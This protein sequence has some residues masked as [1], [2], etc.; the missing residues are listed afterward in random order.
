MKR[1]LT[2]LRKSINMFSVLFAVAL[3]LS[4]VA[5][6][7]PPSRAWV[8]PFFGLAYIPLLLINI[9]FAAF[10]II[11]R[12][13]HAALPL[14]A[15]LLSWNSFFN[16]FAFHLSSNTEKHIGDFRVMSYNVRNFDLYNW[17]ANENTR[18]NMFKQIKKI[19]PD[20]V[21]FQEFMS[22]DEGNYMNV[23]ELTELGY[24]YYHFE[25]TLTLHRTEH[26]GIATFSKFPIV[27]R[28]RV[29]YKNE[30]RNACIY[31]DI[32]VKEKIIRVYNAHLQSVFFGRNDYKFID[33]LE[34][35][36]FSSISR[37]KNILRK[38]KQAFQYRSKQADDVAASISKS[39]Y[40]VIVCTDCNDTPSSYSYRSMRGSLQDA[41]IVKGSGVNHTYNRFLPV[42]RI[43]YVFTAKDFDVKNYFSLYKKYS[44]HYPVITDLSINTIKK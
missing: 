23:K 16:T 40:P 38:M 14:I 22:R 24:K 29:E 43:D 25:K 4:D 32:K 26:W 27:N 30:T 1:V 13:R 15:I 37:A 20:I 2:G 7:V 19:S 42:L 21:C 36:K 8:F 18:S 34:Q 10:W 11:A 33:S 3:L 31:S 5:A 28:Q 17:S 39:P 9:F 44:D 41:F 12:L 35:K 6:Y